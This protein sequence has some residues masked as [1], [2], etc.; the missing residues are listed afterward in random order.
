MF[1][2]DRGRRVRIA[3]A[4]C[5]PCYNNALSVTVILLLTLPIMKGAWGGIFAA[6]ARVRV[7]GVNAVRQHGA[8]GRSMDEDRA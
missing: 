1:G 2:E 6:C 3:S 5:A 7:C 4:M 8:V